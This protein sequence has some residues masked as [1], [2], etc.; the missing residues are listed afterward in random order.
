LKQSV[1]R[2]LEANAV[3]TK[4]GLGRNNIGD[5]GAIAIAKALE[6]NAD[7]K[8]KTLY[9]PNAIVKNPQLVAA[10]REKGVM[11]G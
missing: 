6:V 5:P 3:V 10:C 9:V 4:L 1:T 8:L 2:A 11:L 7:L